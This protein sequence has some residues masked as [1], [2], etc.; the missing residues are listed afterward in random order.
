MNSDQLFQKLK[1]KFGAA[2][3]GGTEWIQIPCPTCLAKDA[4]KMKR[5]I[6][7]NTLHTHCFI[8]EQKLSIF[9]LIGDVQLQRVD[10]DQTR[11]TCE[12]VEHPQS[13]Q[14][15][16]KELLP[17]NALTDDHPAIRFLHKDHLYD[18]DRYWNIF[19][20]GYVSPENAIDIVFKKHDGTQTKISSADSI[21]FPVRFKNELVGWQCRYVPGTPHGDRM[22]KLKY[23][24]VFPKGKYLFNYDNA[25]KYKN[26]VAVEGIKKALKFPNGVATLG[27]GVS[28]R[29][30]QLIQ[31]W[32]NITLLYDGDDKTQEKFSKIAKQ[33]DLGSTKCLNIDPRKYGF[34]SP[35]EMTE[36]EACKIVYLEWLIKN[37]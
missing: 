1:N 20:I 8:C 32:K 33:L 15:P 36:E 23:L 3:W 26:I 21:V 17:I 7:V 16:C 10:G 22:G 9:D 29:Q 2:K 34:P 6:N 5:G 19:G 12:V 28:D 13:R 35:D 30:L 24:H 18:L 14:L 37:G 25:K 11:V 4:P 31:Q 27:K